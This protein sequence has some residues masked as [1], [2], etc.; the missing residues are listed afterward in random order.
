MYSSLP[1]DPIGIFPR[2]SHFNYAALAFFIL[3][4]RFSNFRA[5]A[6]DR[7]TC[8]LD[9]FQSSLRRATVVAYPAVV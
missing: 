8:R 2:Q 7:I 5:I 4:W 1:G 9:I 6:S 3:R